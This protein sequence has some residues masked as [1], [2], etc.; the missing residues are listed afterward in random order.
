[1]S[2]IADIMRFG[3]ETV[4]KRYY[5]VYRG[6]VVDTRDPDQRGRVRVL[7]PY[8]SDEDPPDDYWFE[9]VMAGAGGGR[10][11]FWPPEIGDSVR[12]TFEEGD[13]EKPGVYFGGWYGSPDGKSEVPTALGYSDGQP[14]RRGFVTRGGHMLV[15]DDTVGQE[16]IRMIWHKMSDA[17]PAKT[18]RSK[19]ANTS[20][21]ELGVLSFLSDGSFAVSI[22]NGDRI[23]MDN[24]AGE[25]KLLHVVKSKGN[26]ISGLILD[27][28]G[29]KLLAPDGSYLANEDGEITLNGKNVSLLVKNA[30][31]LGG[32]VFLGGISALQG[33]PLGEALMAW[34]AAHTHTTTAPGVPTSPPLT[35][36]ALAAL[37]SKAIRVK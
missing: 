33:V 24:K 4:A 19:A 18:D 23:H 3:L 9:P 15:L 21:G 32:N 5:G 10:G 14:E 36:S 37:V 22:A 20:L 28:K 25:L 13:V 30:V 2:L 8:V 34:L 6:T 11:S 31:N 17:D 1:M 12:V 16:S 26:K 35:A 29:W 7:V 27:D